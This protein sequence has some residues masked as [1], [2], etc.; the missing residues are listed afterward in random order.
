[1]LLLALLAAVLFAT[2][3]VTLLRWGKVERPV[4]EENGIKQVST[5]EG[6]HLAVYDGSE[7]DE[8]FWTGMNLGAT[9]PGHSPGEL[10]PTREDYLRWFAQMK[11]M[12]IYVLRVYTILNP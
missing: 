1:M 5:V 2:V 12:N 8:Q 11:E 7:W 10:A 6:T 9:L 3:L 4:A